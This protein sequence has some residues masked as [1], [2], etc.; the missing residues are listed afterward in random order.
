MPGAGDTTGPFAGRGRPRRPK[1]GSGGV[2]DWW[3]WLL[4]WFEGSRAARV[5]LYL[6]ATGVIVGFAVWLWVYPW[7]M[8][9]N[10]VKIARDW[11]EAGQLRYAAETAQ[12]AAR[13]DPENP[14]PWRIAAELAR[15]GGQ[16]TEAAGFSR[17]ATELA[18]DD[19]LIQLDLAADLLLSGE[20]DEAATILGRLPLEIVTT[21]AD[22]LRLRGEIARRRGQLA[23]AKD[24]FKRAI[25]LEG[26]RAI[27]Q[28][29]L[30]LILM[31]E[32][33]PQERAQGLAML[34]RWTTDANWGAISLRN[35]LEDAVIRNE[36][37]AMRRWA[38]ALRAHPGCTVADMPRCLQA[39]AVS[40]PER[41][42]EVL[43]ALQRDHAV[44][45]QAAAQLI[46][47]LNQIGRGADAA[48]W[49]PTLPAA[50]L[51]RPP[52]VVVCAEAL[53]QAG[54]RSALLAWTAE[55]DWGAEQDFL[56]WCFALLASR[57]LGQETRAHDLQQSLLARAEF[58]GTHGLF[59]AASLYSWGLT[60][61]AEALWWKVSQSEGPIAVDALGALARHYQVRGDAEGQYRAFRQ[62][63]F[64]QPRDRALANN[65]AFFAALTG[66][67]Q[68]QA[69][70]L[71]QANLKAEPQ[72]LN[73]LATR[74]FVLLQL[75]RAGEALALVSPQAA[76][77]PRAPGVAFAYGLA[78]AR[79]GRRDEA[80][81]LLE[82]LPPSSL[83]KAEVLLIRSELGN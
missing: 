16:Y 55:G 72:N 79:A 66:R 40:A 17:R 70:L 2:R 22:G 78:L 19:P 65:F 75:G 51:R 34:A 82:N 42:A 76:V 26:A 83:T 45:P 11:L 36:A 41:Y 67:D 62:L 1:F 20:T 80:R 47:W 52:L 38:E 18:P 5:A 32:T 37:E 54:D 24:A 68:R 12:R 6:A 53:R 29:P 13:L 4:D 25:R 44:S 15:R 43:A 74:S 49:F 50:A 10:A 57:D 30:G 8:R 56:R 58:N 33:D 21:S 61:E 77:A 14:E 46:S 28:V 35:L 23:V 60:A 9:R 71:S 81:P 69:D 7:W 63:H 3:W 39:L 48:R 31:S 27:N 64:L 59:A 73:Y